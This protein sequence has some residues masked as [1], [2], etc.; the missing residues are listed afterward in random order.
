MTR[1]ELLQANAI[2]SNI[3]V[4]AFAFIITFCGVVTVLDLLLLKFLIFWHRFRGL[5][6]PRIDA[7]VEDGIF[8]LQRRA[9]EAYGQ[10]KWE[11]PDKEVPITI[12][13]ADLAPFGLKSIPSCK[14]AH[15]SPTGVNTLSTFT[16]A[17]STPNG[18]EKAGIIGLGIDTTFQKE[19]IIDSKTASDPSTPQPNQIITALS[20]SCRDYHQTA[21]DASVV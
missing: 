16:T 19:P 18:G 11:F 5:L 1:A 21:T 9:Y 13:D 17:V 12:D 10:G 20:T 8:Q 6:S 15:S 14:Y 2:D 3:N 7:W 4:F